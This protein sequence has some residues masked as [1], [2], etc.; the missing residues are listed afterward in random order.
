VNWHIGAT[1]GFMDYYGDIYTSGPVGV[2]F[3]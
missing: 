3:Q 1:G 2:P